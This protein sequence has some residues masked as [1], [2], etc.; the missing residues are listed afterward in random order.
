MAGA[1]D[2]GAG[3]PAGR[4]LELSRGLAAELSR[5]VARRLSNP[6][7]AADIVQQTALLACAASGEG[8]IDD[9]PRWLFTVAH[10][11]VVDHYRA[12]RRYRF[13]GLAPA[14]VEEEAA[15]Q[16]RPDLALAVVECHEM[17]GTLLDRIARLAWVEHQVAILMSDVY[18]YGDKYSSA[19]L[20]MSVPCFKLLLHGARS[21]LGAI[22]GTVRCL[23]CPLASV[24]R[25]QRLGV[26]CG[27]PSPELLAVQAR[28]LEG[29][30][31]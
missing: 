30:G 31:R 9:L 25:L 17:L 1:V 10:H 4:R 8:R 22:S 7:D 16:T 20:R 28:L 13:T 21:C 3:A 6:D 19:E 27:L 18:G 15:L 14:L 29:L 11:L 12:Q 24:C 2:Q 26:T 23:G 5:F